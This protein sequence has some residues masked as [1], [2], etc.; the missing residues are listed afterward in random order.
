LTKKSKGGAKKAEEKGLKESR[1]T[2]TGLTLKST[3]QK[4]ETRVSDKHKKSS[5]LGDRGA[6]KSHKNE[7]RLFWEKEKRARDGKRR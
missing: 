4:R 3:A 2:G 7:E 1:K 5:G 6:R